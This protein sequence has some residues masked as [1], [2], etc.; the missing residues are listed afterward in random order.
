MC[1]GCH[2]RARSGLACVFCRFVD[3]G[4]ASQPT[5]GLTPDNVQAV[6]EIC[7]RL[8]GLPLAIELAAAQLRVLSPRAILDRLRAQAPFVLGGAQDLPVRH[9]TLEAAVAS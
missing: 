3:R 8:D 4:R 9:Q 6:T 1:R 2:G 7:A 5:F